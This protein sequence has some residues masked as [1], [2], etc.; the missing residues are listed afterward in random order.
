M[1]AL[2][3]ATV[4]RSSPSS[5]AASAG[6]TLIYKG[7][8]LLAETATAVVDVLAKYTKL[9]HNYYTTMRQPLNAVWWETG[10]RN[11]YIQ[12]FGV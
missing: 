5:T 3:V 2:P 6:V 4:G 8:A 11:P 9:A 7:V 1:S 12:E 10:C